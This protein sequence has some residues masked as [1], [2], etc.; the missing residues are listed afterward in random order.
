VA[1]DLEA[2][3]RVAIE[4]AKASRAEGN[5][6]YGA[7]VLLDGRIIAQAHDTAATNR[8]PSQHAEFNAIRAACRILD[9]ADLR[10]AIL[11][12]TCEPCPM[13]SSLAVW[14]N[15]KM[16]A[17]GAS[18]HETALRGKAR[19]KIPA[20]EVIE[21]SPVAVEVIGGVLREECLELYY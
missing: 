16:I 10:S 12:S 13:C 6:G 8:D 1:L 20:L 4:E 7:L 19:I 17:F 21:R 3:M 14:A 5:K 15:L 11:V 18:I 9:S 2:L